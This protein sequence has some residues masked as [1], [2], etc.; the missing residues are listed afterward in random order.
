VAN[1]DRADSGQ[2]PKEREVVDLAAAL[3]ASVEAAKQR[4]EASI[5]KR[6]EEGR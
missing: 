2:E 5:Q 1:E 3:R 6:M 4:R